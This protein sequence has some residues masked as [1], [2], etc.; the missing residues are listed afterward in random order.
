MNTGQLFV[1]TIV[2]MVVLVVLFRVIS[3]KCFL[4]GRGLESLENIYEMAN[5]EVSR[6]IF[7]ETFTKIGEIFSIDP[8]L[9]RP[10]DKFKDLLVI[11]SWTLGA[12][13]EKLISWLRKEKFNFPVELISIIDL[14]KFMENSR[15]VGCAERIGTHQND[16]I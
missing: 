14:V 5:E 9:L 10:D 11:D 13:E 8:R 4:E 3:K 15:A 2:V 7:I 1:L 12:G 6:Y 16:M